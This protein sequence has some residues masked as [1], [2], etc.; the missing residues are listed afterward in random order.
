MYERVENEIHLFSP[1]SVRTTHSRMYQ[2]S[3][4]EKVE[5]TAPQTETVVEATEASTD[6]SKRDELSLE[7]I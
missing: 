1:T 5:E 3:T 6:G 7:N 2:S 4:N